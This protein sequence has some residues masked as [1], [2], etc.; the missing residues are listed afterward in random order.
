MQRVNMFEGLYQSIWNHLRVSRTPL[1][2]AKSG[3][4][5][6]QSIAHG[7][8]TGPVTAWTYAA[9]FTTSLSMDHFQVQT[10]WHSREGRVLNSRMWSV[11]AATKRIVVKRETEAEESDGS[12]LTRLSSNEE[13]DAKQEE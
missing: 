4:F 8:I 1:Q 13:E 3:P 7:A 11:A 9:T 5:F 10:R 2:P 12:T 6:S